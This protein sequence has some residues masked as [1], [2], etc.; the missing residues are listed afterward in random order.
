MVTISDILSLPSIR[1]AE[2][3]APCDGGGD[4]VVR[5]VGILDVGP[6]I[7]R[8]RAYMPGE[9]ILTNLGFAKGDPKAS[10]DAL[11]A[12]ID[13]GVAGIGIKTVYGP[14]VSDAV[15][16]RSTEAGVPV[17]L[18]DGAYHE[19]VIYEALSIIKEDADEAEREQR[20][21]HLIDGRDAEETR[22]ELHDLI[23][24]SADLVQCFA[25]RPPQGHD[26][27]LEFRAM[28]SNLTAACQAYIPSHDDVLDAFVCHYEDVLLVIGSL[29]VSG[30]P[31]VAKDG[32]PTGLSAMMG[33]LQRGVSDIVEAGDC[34]IAIRQALGAVDHATEEHP[35]V[36]WSEM[37][38]DAFLQ[39]ACED[40]LFARAQQATR[41]RIE[42]AGDGLVELARA[43]VR[44][45]GDIDET[46]QELGQ[47]PNTVRNR[48]VR[49][50]AALGMEDASLR[51]LLSFLTLVCLD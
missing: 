38:A 40:R 19:Y 27:Q 39:A 30:G 25:V 24:T 28:Q 17:Y 37:G 21:R 42:A 46:A 7:N 23:G 5:N 33:N 20:V 2:L 32:G 4:R 48:L 13:R 43:Y 6:E 12:M 47:H 51:G 26:D 44:N 8:Y 1:H 36:T 31:G 49:V 41:A 3:I 18:Y 11:L 50:R 10:D 16:R 9:F 15:R 35:V 14:Y 45:F 29:S 22:A 34:D